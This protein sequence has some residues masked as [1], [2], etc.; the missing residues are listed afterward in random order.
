M[1]AYTVR[2]TRQALILSLEQLELEFSLEDGGMRALRRP[3]EADL[4]GHGAARPSVDVS[5]A[6]TGWLTERSFARYLNHTLAETAD[7]VELVMIIGLGPLKIYD[8]Y[9]VA[10]SLITRRISIENA[11]ID[12]VAHASAGRNAA[13]L[14]RR[15]M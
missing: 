5:L 9:R 14:R 1:S 12:E 6:D 3:G 11:G 13:D 7:G 4:T 8:R 15:R 10:G 2:F